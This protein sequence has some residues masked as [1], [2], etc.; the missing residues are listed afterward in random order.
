MNM[1]AIN[2]LVAAC[3][4]G[5]RWICLGC[6]RC[7]S[8]SDCHDGHAG[9]YLSTRRLLEENKE[10]YSVDD[11]DQAG[12]SFTVLVV[13]IIVMCI[14]AFLIYQCFIKVNEYDELAE[15][16]NQMKDLV[17][18][19]DTSN[20]QQMTGQ[21]GLYYRKFST[22]SDSP[23]N[24]NQVRKLRHQYSWSITPPSTNQ[25]HP[26]GTPLTMPLLFSPA[27]NTEAESKLLSR[28]PMPSN[29]SFGD[30]SNSPLLFDSMAPHLVDSQ[31]PAPKIASSR[32]PTLAE[33]KKMKADEA[34][35]KTPKSQRFESEYVDI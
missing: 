17:E 30:S 22:E 25:R 5:Y 23:S 6:Y 32:F 13:V 26:T 2:A 10:K 8:Y 27:I 15:L 29:N 34:N 18:L 1:L 24:M 9:Y 28:M 33:I 20:T 7:Y 4:A 14:A 16:N 11:S 3:K 19:Q 31:M 35:N 21:T 12:R